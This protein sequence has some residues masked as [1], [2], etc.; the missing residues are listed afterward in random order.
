MKKDRP[1]TRTMKTKIGNLATAML[2]VILSIGCANSQ[3]RPAPF[4]NEL[5]EVTSQT[6]KN[7]LTPAF[8]LSS[9]PDGLAIRSTQRIET[10]I[11]IQTASTTPFPTLLPT[12]TSAQ[13][14]ASETLDS[15]SS[16]LSQVLISYSVNPGDGVDEVLSCMHGYGV[17]R[18]VLYQGGHLIIFDEKQYLETV[19]S[20]PEIDKLL[21]DIETTGYFSLK[22]DGDQYGPTAPTPTYI[23]GWSSSIT[24]QGKTINIDARS[25]Y[26]VTSVENVSQIIGNF[27]PPNL[28]P[29]KPNS[30]QVWA[31]SIQDTSFDSYNPTPQP[32]I[33][34]WSFDSI[35]LKALT[36]E[37]HTIS[38]NTA[39]FLIDQVQTIPAFR[40]VEQNG[41]N[42]LVLICPNLN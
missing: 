24:V 13:T 15:P 39:S 10:V 32:P 27:R 38:D 31:L 29:Y 42:Y 19:L 25:K 12:Q 28:K 41:Q 33:L 5:F 8:E 26:L 40:M 35:Q 23:G 16:P 21:N 2:V 18:F 20:Q 17:Y 1:S 34:K 14:I 4:P 30:L 11:A 22:G 9:T 37:P 6:P 36:D 3:S 7:P